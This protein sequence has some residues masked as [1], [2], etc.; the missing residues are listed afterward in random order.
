LACLTLYPEL[1]AAGISRVGISNFITFLSNTAEYRREN[2]EAEYGS[3]SYDF[4]FLESIS[5][6]NKVDRIK[7]PLLLIH[8][9]ND[10]RVPVNE[11]EQI[12]EAIKSKGGVVEFL[13]FED[14]GHSLSRSDNRLTAYKKIV[15]FIDKHVEKE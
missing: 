2:R 12:Y 13:K 9:E 4:G 6:I 10:P 11:A 15:E 14:E 7:A 8:G 5:P 1:F 3:L